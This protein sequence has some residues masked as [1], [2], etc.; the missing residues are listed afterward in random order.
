MPR[1]G[2]TG[3]QTIIRVARNRDIDGSWHRDVN[4]ESPPRIGVN[5]APILPILTTPGTSFNYCLIT[6]GILRKAKLWQ[7]VGNLFANSVIA[8]HYFPHDL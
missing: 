8:S 2:Y 5:H 4:V 3:N 6:R 7:G 1:W